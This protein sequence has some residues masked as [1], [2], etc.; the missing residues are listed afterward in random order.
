MVYDSSLNTLNLSGK[1]K[2]IDNVID[3]L[4]WNNIKLAHRHL[5]MILS[6]LEQER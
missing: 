1:A 2:S 4:D 3:I 6:S 5:L